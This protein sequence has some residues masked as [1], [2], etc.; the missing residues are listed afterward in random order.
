[1]VFGQV[2]HFCLMLLALENSVE[3]ACRLINLVVSKQ[4]YR[5]NERWIS[6]KLWNVIK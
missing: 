5:L 1:M 6:S 2:V 4:C 3:A